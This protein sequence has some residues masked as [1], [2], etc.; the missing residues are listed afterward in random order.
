VGISW[1]TTQYTS[2]RP[3][4]EALRLRLREL[5]ATHV[6]YGYRRLT[7]LLGREGWKLNA[8]R[9][10]RLH[11][12]ENLKVRGVERKKISRRQRVAQGP[13]S[14][15]NQ[16]WSAELVSDEL[17]DGRSM[18]LHSE[19]GVLLLRHVVASGCFPQRASTAKSPQFLPVLLLGFASH[20]TGFCLSRHTDDIPEST[21]RMDDGHK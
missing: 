11:D 14:R 3:L 18:L 19:T 15:P 17:A 12:E 8:K 21:L 2:S 9:I 16:C 7:V 6:R 13:A 4:Q 10:Y 1:G 5:A 20:P